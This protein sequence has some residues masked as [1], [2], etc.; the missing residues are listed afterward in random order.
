[1]IGLEKNA[2]T[3]KLAPV[4]RR[5]LPDTEAFDEN[6]NLTFFT[7]GRPNHFLG[8]SLLDNK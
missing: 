3:N 7:S 5:R 1:M 8:I 4:V 6:G 2:A